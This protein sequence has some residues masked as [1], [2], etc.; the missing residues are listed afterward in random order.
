LSRTVEGIA[1]GNR[2]ARCKIGVVVSQ[3]GDFGVSHIMMGRDYY[4]SSSMSGDSAA[5]TCVS[6]LPFSLLSSCLF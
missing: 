2:V 1:C 5:A 3:V 4:Y 6:P